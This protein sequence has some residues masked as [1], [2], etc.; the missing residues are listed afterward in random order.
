MDTRWKPSV[1]V[2]AII[3]QNGKFLLVEE[4]TP[5]GLK[6]NNPAGHL[7]PGES[8]MDACARETQEE[9]THTFR[10]TALVGAYMTRFQRPAADQTPAEDTT[11][12]RFAFCGELGEVQ[13]GS[14][15]DTGIVRTLW[16]T[17]TRF[18]PVRLDT[19]VPCSCA[20]WKTTWQGNVIRWPCST[21]TPRYCYRP[22]SRA[23]L[24]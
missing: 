24:P 13:V 22:N 9:T 8:L 10:P 16:M 1:T 15:L 7:E 3:E 6:L 21:P 14:Q 4:R 18:A 12:L 17:L 19:A 2:A 20:A 5:E 23:A 11:Y